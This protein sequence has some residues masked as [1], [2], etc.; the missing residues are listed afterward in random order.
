MLTKREMITRVIELYGKN[1]KIALWF[2][3][4]ALK[5]DYKR[6]RSIFFKIIEKYHIDN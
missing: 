1:S 3:G 2:I 6:T 5:G 4:I